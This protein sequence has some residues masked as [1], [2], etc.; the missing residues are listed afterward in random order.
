[1]KK[2]FLFFLF[3]L[4][5]NNIKAQLDLEHWFPSVFSSGANV[6]SAVVSLSTDKTIP[7]NVYIYNGNNLVGNV[8]IDKYNPIEYDLVV[9]NIIQSVYTSFIGDTM[10]PLDR[11]LHL[12]GENS[13]Y[14]N[15][16]YVGANTEIISSKGKSALGKSFFVVN[17]QN[18][19]NGSFNPNPMNYQ[20]SIT[21]YYDNTKIKISGYKNGLKFTNGSTNNEINI[22]LNKNQSYIVAALKKDNTT[23]ALNDYFDPHLIGATIVSDKPIVVNNGNLLS[24]D[25]ALDGGSVNIDQS[26]PVD[27]LG[28]EYLVVNGMAAGKYFTEKAI[29][30]ATEDGT[31]I[32][33]NNENTPLFTL[34]KGEHYIGPYQADKKFI[35]GSE[36]SFINEEGREITTSAMFIRA[37]K[38]IYC[39]QLLATFYDKPIDPRNYVYKVDKTSAMLFSYPLDKEYQIKNVTI[40]FIDDIGGQEMRSKLSIKTEKNANIKINGVQLTG[41]TDILGKPNWIYH[42]IQNSKG[43][44][45]IE[46]DKSLNVDFVGG[47]TTAYSSSYSGYAGSVVSYSNDPFITM[48]GNCIEEGL[49]L[50]LNNTDFDKIQWQKDGVDIVGANQATYIP[51]EPG[52]YTCVLTYSNVTYTTNSFNITHCPY[53]V[54]DKDFGKI[55]DDIAFTPKFSTPNESEKI[56]KLEIL[57]EPMYGKVIKDNLNL[58]Y[59]PNVDFT[60]D[61]RFVYRICT[62][63]MGL[64]ETIKASV[65][66]N[67]RPVAEIKPELYPISESNGKGKYDLTETIID[68][69]KNDYKFYEDSDLTKFIDKPEAYETALL[70]A[71]VK[72]TSPTDC[73]I[74]KEIK[75]LTLQENI[76]L[77][78]FFSPN[79]DGI[80][81]FWDY[82]KLKDYSEL[83]ISIYNKIGSKV[84]EHSISNTDFKWNGKDYSGKPLSSNTYWSLLKWKNARTGVPISKQMWILLKSI[85]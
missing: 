40:P 32:F 67:E 84:F 73:F 57:T 11:G 27:K 61:D 22:T 6:K 8:K 26:M 59:I 78:N 16:K 38:P 21:A 85:D 80:N 29:I 77:P 65:F 46:S 37:T 83:E 82:S 12:V 58:K 43:N 30:V 42:T 5:Q 2:L 14:A 79:G 33:F 23:G 39:Y 51:T 17:D 10:I 7:F 19:L 24:Q 15:L 25:A 1:M 72:I 20:A 56:S 45:V 48:N 75:L 66:V 54:V 70:T 4:F 68:K 44:V 63:T 36:S 81:D 64:C 28:K 74:K 41:G 34:N 69:G 62:E 9:A 35:E 60:G 49:L 18:L 71:Y 47:T 52:L 3:L 50:K 13:F 31:Q 53:T 55:C 76:E